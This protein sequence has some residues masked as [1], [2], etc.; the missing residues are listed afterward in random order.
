MSEPQVPKLSKLPFL[1]GDVLLLMTA[2]FICARAESPLGPIPLVLLCGCVAFGAGLAIFPYWLEY[3]TVSRLVEGE[4]LAS[5]VA[6]LQQLRALCEQ[7]GGATHQWQS[8]QDGAKQTADSARQIVDLISTELKGFKEFMQRANDTEK[9]HLRLEVEK[10]HRAESDWLQVLVRTLDHVYA[11]NIGA[12]RSG[13]PTLIEQLG[14]FQEACRDAA[15]R[16]GL[17]PF[18]A[19]REEA[20]DSQRHQVLEAEGTPPAGALVSETVATGYSFQG[21]LLRPALVR[22][23][24]PSG[25]AA[26]SATV[27]DVAPAAP[28]PATEAPPTNPGPDAAQP[29]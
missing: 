12:Q 15:R 10:L 1:A 7:V 19:A 22:L 20:F 23:Q 5:A 18:V 9:N 27:A 14:H 26:E 11:L 25:G 8:V 6:D 28:I 3:R 17:V 21:R 2:G 4:Q 24:S 13:Q 29:E 16:V